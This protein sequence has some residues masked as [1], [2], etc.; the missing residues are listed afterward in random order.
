MTWADAGIGLL[1]FIASA[2]IDFANT[3]YVQA[4]N[5]VE[6]HG[7]ARWSV[8]QWTASLVGFVVAVKYS[9]WI[10]PVEAAG[11]YAGAWLSLR[12]QQL[13]RILDPE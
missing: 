11:L 9:L 12:K 3:R 6:P 7:A 4:V 13:R 10:L 2:A 5:A 1:V 8:L